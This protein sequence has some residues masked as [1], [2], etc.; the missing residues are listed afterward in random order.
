MPSRGAV[1]ENTRCL[2]G[3]EEATLRAIERRR[4]GLWVC[5]LGVDCLLVESESKRIPR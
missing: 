4:G 1:A 3:A 2:G 5:F